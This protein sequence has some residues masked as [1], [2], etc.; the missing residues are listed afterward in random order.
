MPPRYPGRGANDFKSGLRTVWQHAHLVNVLAPE[1][2]EV[3]RCRK[4]SLCQ[5]RIHAADAKPFCQL[6]RFTASYASRLN[7]TANG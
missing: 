7:S 3:L 2:T 5:N 1:A 4:A 6:L